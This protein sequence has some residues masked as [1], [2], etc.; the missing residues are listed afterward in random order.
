MFFNLRIY[1]H[2]LSEKRLYKIFDLGTDP[3][4]LKEDELY[5]PGSV[6]YRD[7]KVVWSGGN[8]QNTWQSLANFIS[9]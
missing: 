9:R 7:T 3:E 4:D 2:P 5:V 6:C 8:W 1:L